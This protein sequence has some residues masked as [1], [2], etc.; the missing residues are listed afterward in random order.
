[1]R[2]TPPQTRHEPSP[3]VYRP[4][5]PLPE[6]AIDGQF[7]N[8][9]HAGI[10]EATKDLPGWQDPGDSLKLYEAAYHS[11]SVI[12]EIGV[13]GGRSAAVELKGALAAMRDH[14]GGAPQFY[15]VDPD[16]AVFGR[17]MGTL[18]GLDLA[19]RAL[20]YTGDFR[21]FISD[22][23]IVPTMVFVD[24]SHEYDGVWAD[25]EALS[26]ILVPG[27]AVMCHDYSN[28]DVPGVRKAIDEWSAGPGGLGAYEL[29]GVSENTAVLRAGAAC[30]GKA[31]QGLTEAT[32]RK[33]ADALAARYRQQKPGGGGGRPDV[34]HLTHDA[35]RELGA[36]AV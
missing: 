5:W 20:L 22:L 11:G 36:A 17:A 15:G 1:M 30:R 26:R 25:L 24:G 28:S 27:T 13:F 19:G 3:N 18:D 6:G 23:P 29:W 8:E 10:Y 12:L 7:I 34:A 4:S 33:T 31:P 2:F 32:F 21:Q 35:R 9:E 14:G 16:P